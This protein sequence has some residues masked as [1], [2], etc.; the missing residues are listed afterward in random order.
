VLTFTAL[1]YLVGFYD[2]KLGRMVAFGILFS[3]HQ[4]HPAD[5]MFY[6]FTGGR[7]DF[8]GILPHHL[9]AI[10]SESLAF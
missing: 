2:K 1:K 6:L 10:T 8:G 3:T 9:G 4:R 7:V 5:F